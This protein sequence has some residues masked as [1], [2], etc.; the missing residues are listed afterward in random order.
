[1]TDDMMNL[2]ALVEKTP[3]AVDGN[4][5]LAVVKALYDGVDGGTVIRATEVDTGPPSG[6]RYLVRLTGPYK[7]LAILPESMSE[8]V[9]TDVV[10][11]RFGSFYQ[12]CSTWWP[13]G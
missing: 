11:R 3:D 1:M 6:T 2:R 5:I 8:T 9:D 4:R 13:A 10:R 12:L 7:E